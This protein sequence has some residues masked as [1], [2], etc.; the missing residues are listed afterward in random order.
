M[1]YISSPQ[2]MADLARFVLAPFAL[3]LH[4]GAPTGPHWKNILPEEDLRNLTSAYP[5]YQ[6][7][8]AIA[9]LRELLGEDVIPEPIRMGSTKPNFDEQA[10]LKDA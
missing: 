6:D 10:G 9:Y 1:R 5:P 8:T 2:R 4:S 7:L 3:H